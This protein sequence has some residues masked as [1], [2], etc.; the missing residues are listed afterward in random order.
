MISID[1]VSDNKLWSKKIKKPDFFF[2][3]FA[4]VFPKKYRFIKKKVS[5]IINFK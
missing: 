2:N 3:S 1:V 5:I 4:K